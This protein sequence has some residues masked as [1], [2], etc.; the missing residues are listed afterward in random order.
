MWKLKLSEPHWLWWSLCCGVVQV[1]VLQ[2]QSLSLA[3]ACGLLT[4]SL[5]LNQNHSQSFIHFLAISGICTW[6]N[7]RLVWWHFL[8]MPF[9]LI[10]YVCCTRYCCLCEGSWLLCSVPE[11][12]HKHVAWIW[13]SQSN[14]VLS[15]VCSSDNS[16]VMVYLFD[17]GN[18]FHICLGN[19][20]YSVASV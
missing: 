6:E 12:F 17:E 16:W 2:N 3:T 11:G 5:P 8:V 9:V 7:S 18:L 14:P 10:S 15:L 13:V 4:S 19:C 1:A 20:M